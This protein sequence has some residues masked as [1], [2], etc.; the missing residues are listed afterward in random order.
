MP[1]SSIFPPRLV[2]T[3]LIAVVAATACGSVAAQTDPAAGAGSGL[4]PVLGITLTNGGEKLATVSYTDGSSQNIK[5]GALL[6]LFGGFEFD[7]GSA[8]VQAT[9]GY[10]V[11][12]TNATNGSVRFVRYPVE[13]LGFWKLADSWRVGGGARKALN[14]RLTSSGAASSLGGA[15]LEG[16]AGL[17]LQAEYLFGQGSVFGRVV[18]EDYAIGRA[19][20]GGNHIGLG[21]AYRF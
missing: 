9:I 8:V 19:K 11:D 4:R 12:D 21:V 10:H 2:G 6:H 1:S 3:A 16:E 14:A 18:R 20:T 17:V 7:L 15:E 13:V 5:S